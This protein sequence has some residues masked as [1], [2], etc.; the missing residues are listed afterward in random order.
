MEVIL[1]C[2]LLARKLEKAN[3]GVYCEHPGLV[4]TNL[5]RNVNWISSS[6]FRLMGLPPEKGAET[7][8]YLAEED[9]SKLISG[10]YY[11]KKSVTKTTP[12]SNDLEVAQKLLV[13]LKP[14]FSKYIGASSN[15]SL[16]LCA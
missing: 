8:I 3:V 11:Y 10:E 9:K 5:T 14:Y 15:N 1:L 7:M 12:Q 16:E 4:N 2:R 6:F 13:A